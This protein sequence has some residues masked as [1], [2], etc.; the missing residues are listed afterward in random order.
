MQ[1]FDHSGRT[2]C[3]TASGEPALGDAARAAPR[4]APH[5]APR[6]SRAAAARCRWRGS[7]RGRCRPA[8]PP[9]AALSAASAALAFQSCPSAQAHIDRAS[10]GTASRRPAARAT[11]L[12]AAH[13][14]LQHLQALTMPSPVVWRS[15]ASRWPE[16]SPPS[17]QPRAC[18]ALPA[19]SGRRP[20][21][22]RTRC[23]AGCSATS[24]ALLVIS[25]PTTPASFSPRARRSIDHQ[26]EQLVAVEEAAARRRPAA[27][28]R[29]RR[30]ARCR[31]RRRAPAPRRSGPA[32]AWRR[33]PC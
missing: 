23:P 15:S 20:W 29:R 27:G 8:R 2:H 11:R 9:R 4:P 13:A 24:T 5:R 12:A 16:P 21:R 18:R 33:S 10:A 28:G 31:S 19:H 30:R 17:S 7:A 14:G 1:D 22:A 26:V 32:D 6:P 3:R 25:V